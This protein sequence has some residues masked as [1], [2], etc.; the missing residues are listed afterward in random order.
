MTG[1][2]HTAPTIYLHATRRDLPADTRA[3]RRPSGLLQAL[4]RL[5]GRTSVPALP[6]WVDVKPAS[7]AR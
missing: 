6:R 7:A 3:A 4:R 1:I 2:H 5:T